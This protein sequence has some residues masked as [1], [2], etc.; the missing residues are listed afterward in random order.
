M[1]VPEAKDLR[2]GKE[3]DDPPPS[4]TK[5]KALCKFRWAVVPQQKGF[6]RK[7]YTAA[8]NRRTQERELLHL[9]VA[10]LRDRVFSQDPG[11][12]GS[13]N[14]Q[15]SNKVHRW[16]FDED[17]RRRPGAVNS[18]TV[19]GHKA[20]GPDLPHLSLHSLNNC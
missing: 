2:G 19:E 18:S 15:N 5:D 4:D 13:L 16:F 3:D 1:G 17:H 12:L 8:A 7:D 14:N 11:E 10:S 6:L 20:M 9:D